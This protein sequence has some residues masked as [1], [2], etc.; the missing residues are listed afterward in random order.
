MN[1]LFESVDDILLRIES[2]NIVP[3]GR[4][5]LVITKNDM[6]KV[7]YPCPLHFTSYIKCTT[8]Y[9]L[10]KFGVVTLDGPDAKNMHK[11]LNMS[12]NRCLL[13]VRNYIMTNSSR[14][15]DQLKTNTGYI[16]SFNI[17]PGS[18]TCINC[19][20]TEC[21]INNWTISLM[22]PEQF[23]DDLNEFK[24]KI[25]TN[26]TQRHKDVKE[27]L[28]DPNLDPRMCVC[29]T[30]HRF[31]Y[32]ADS[33]KNL[34]CPGC[35]TWVCAQC[36]RRT[37]KEQDEPHETTCSESNRWDNYLMNVPIRFDLTNTQSSFSDH[38]ITDEL[39]GNKIIVS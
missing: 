36:W 16:K 15:F 27:L 34:L 24:S 18:V 19:V 7:I 13:P 10:I 9:D 2:K 21:K 20:E 26:L 23:L 28:A 5:V 31:L 37:H 8:C 32:W 12:D 33:C 14:L 39:T 25:E 4:R 11:I 22:T 6:S 30:C 35:N 3:T 29:G 38:R 1:K 17:F